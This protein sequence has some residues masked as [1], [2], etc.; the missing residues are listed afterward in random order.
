MS[1]NKD[2]LLLDHMNELRKVIIV[3]VV[4]VVVCGILVFTIGNQWLFEYITQP[5]KAL[6]VPLITTGVTDAFIAKIKLSLIAGLFISMPLLIYLVW[7]FAA[8]A[9]LPQEKK[10]VLLLAPIVLILFVGGSAFAYYLVLPLTLNFLLIMATE[11][12]SPMITFSG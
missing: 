3:A 4:A 11:G 9:L 5:I 7:G 12:L 10:I 8:P 1:K 6:N 2:M